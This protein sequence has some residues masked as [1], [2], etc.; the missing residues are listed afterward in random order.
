MQSLD[1]IFSVGIGSS[2]RGGAFEDDSDPGQGIPCF[3][4][5]STRYFK[6]RLLL[7]R[8]IG[9]GQGLP[10][11]QGNRL[12]DNG[13]GERLIPETDIQHSRERHFIYFDAYLPGALEPGIVINKII[14]RLHPD[15]AE[16]PF[17]RSIPQ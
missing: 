17:E 1:R 4:G 13:L 6:A 10:G 9:P 15:F 14:P 5:Y 12:P 7:G 16:H 11:L 2:A 3:A 8:S